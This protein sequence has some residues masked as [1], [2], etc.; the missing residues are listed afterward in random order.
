MKKNHTM[1]SVQKHY[2]EAPPKPPK[3]NVINVKANTT[4]M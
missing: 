1:W 3:P 2:I 4:K